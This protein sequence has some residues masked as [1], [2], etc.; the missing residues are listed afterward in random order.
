MKWRWPHPQYVYRN[1]LEAQMRSVTSNAYL[2][3]IQRKKKNGSSN[4]KMK[5]VQK[6]TTAN[7]TAIQHKKK[8]Y[9]ASP[10]WY[11]IGQVTFPTLSTFFCSFSPCLFYISPFSLLSPF[12]AYPDTYF[13]QNPHPKNV[14]LILPKG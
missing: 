13:S 5:G 14:R 9:T 1:L 6:K 10:T 3:S 7:L 8:V 4:K 11:M 12:T 2:R